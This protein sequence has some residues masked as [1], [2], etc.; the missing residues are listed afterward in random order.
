MVFTAEHVKGLLQHDLV[1]ELEKEKVNIIAKIK[2]FSNPSQ[3][4][5]YERLAVSKTVCRDLQLY[6]NYI[7]SIVISQVDKV[8]GE[9][10]CW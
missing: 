2:Q 5:L 10:K 1:T 6:H 9:M 4:K 3:C 7:F 8:V